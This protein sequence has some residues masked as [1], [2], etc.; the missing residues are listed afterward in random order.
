MTQRTLPTGRSLLWRMHALTVLTPLPALAVL[1]ACLFTLL[2]LTREQWQWFVA[3]VG[4][5]TLVFAGPI[6]VF[7]RRSVAAIVAWLERRDESRPR[8]SGRRRPSPPA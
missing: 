5:Y 4:L 3:A 6:M 7:Q 2:E 8:R 1:L